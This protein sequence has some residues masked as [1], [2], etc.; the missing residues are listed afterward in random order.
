[1]RNL[2]NPDIRPSLSLEMEGPLCLGDLSRAEN[3][4]RTW[5]T[6]IKDPR[7]LIEEVEA[8]GEPDNRR[9]TSHQI[10]RACA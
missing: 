10:A 4:A 3:P 6:H 8:E 2:R 9:L 5:A 7:A 1:M